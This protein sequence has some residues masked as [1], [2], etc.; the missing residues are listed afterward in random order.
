MRSNPLDNLRGPNARGP[1]A[2]GAAGLLVLAGLGVVVHVRTE[3][4]REANIQ[5]VLAARGYGPAEI[6]PMKGDECWRAR[7]GFRWRTATASG[8]ACAGPRDA[9]TL[10]VTEGAP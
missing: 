4:A 9:V 6:E 1:L 2:V 8:T 5:R 3:G 10:K 7:E